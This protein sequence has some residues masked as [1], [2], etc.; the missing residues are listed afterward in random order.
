MSEEER[1]RGEL[2]VKLL[3]FMR[4]RFGEDKAV[5]LGEIVKA[6]YGVDNDKTRARARSLI[7]RVR[8]DLARF[9]I[10]LAGAYKDKATGHR[11]FIIGK[12]EDYEEAVKYF[13]EYYLRNKEAVER[14]KAE[15]ANESPA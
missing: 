10:T 7:S 11:Y 9:N 5:T 14:R 8:K 6:L 15:K 4:G 1:I 2:T 13:T 3:E 12:P